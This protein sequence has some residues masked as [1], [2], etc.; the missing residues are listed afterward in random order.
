MFKDLFKL[1]DQEW[2]E[3]QPKHTQE[4]LKKQA[5]WHDADLFRFLAI[6]ML[7]GFLIGLIF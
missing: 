1:P 7:V 2:L 5:I 4:W 6:G 3:K